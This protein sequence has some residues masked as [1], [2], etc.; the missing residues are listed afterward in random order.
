MSN[1]S[2]ERTSHES[3]INFAA[4]L[5]FE[6]MAQD[7]ELMAA[8][9]AAYCSFHLDLDEYADAR[10]IPLKEV[11]GGRKWDG[12]HM[13]GPMPREDGRSKRVP[14]SQRVALGK[15][16]L[17]DK[18]HVT[19]AARKAGTTRKMAD[20]ILAQLAPS[21]VQ[22]RRDERAQRIH[23]SSKWGA[24]LEVLSHTECMSVDIPD[25]EDPFIYR[26]RLRS[27]LPQSK[28]TNRWRWSVTGIGRKA[29][30]IRIGSYHD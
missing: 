12:F 23:R 17:I 21:E 4:P 25:T 1:E 26:T 14:F 18:Q 20:R 9:G 11:S 10:R 13:T 24:L 27:I 15:L 8:S 2:R 28:R 3:A 6:C 19:E 29:K 30:I 22:R 5:N 7:C 16:L